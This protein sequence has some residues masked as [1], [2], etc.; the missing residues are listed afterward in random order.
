M[1]TLRQGF[2]EQYLTP[3]R[4]A[5]VLRCA[6]PEEAVRGHLE[7]AWVRAATRF[8]FD[9]LWARVAN[10]FVTPALH[11]PCRYF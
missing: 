10:I 5:D 6:S 2:Q 1:Q 9:A 7:K 8:S 3:E 11:S 4:V